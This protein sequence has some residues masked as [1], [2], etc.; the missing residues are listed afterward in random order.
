M[1]VRAGGDSLPSNSYLMSEYPDGLD[2]ATHRDLE[3][4]PHQPWVRRVIL[5]MLL[6]AVVLALANIFGQETEVT[7]AD[8]PAA[9]LSI[10]APGT[11]RGGLLFQARVEVVAHSAVDHPRLVFD[12]GWLEGMQ[13]NTIEPGAVGETSR[14]GRLVLSYDGL[15]AGD[16]LTVWF[17]FQSDPTYTGSRDQDIEL[18]DATTP[19][20]TIDRT[21]HVLP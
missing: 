16:R 3:G 11:V 19:L 8:G 21:L 1:R 17:Q 10:E 5:T 7:T 12:R 6:V 13:I 18:D 4:R 9:T 15:E 2:P 14:D 20:A